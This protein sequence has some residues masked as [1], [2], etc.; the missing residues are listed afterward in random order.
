MSD[1]KRLVKNVTPWDL[2]YVIDM[3]IA[4]GISYA[5]I[6]RVLVSFVDRPDDL[7]GG[8]WAV[9]ATVFVF[10]DSRETS[11]AAGRDR[12]IA[13]GISFA[14]CLAYFLIVPFSPLGMGV[15]I[16][17][18]SIV[19]IL[20]G[21]RD[22]IITTGI[23]TAVVMVAA[24]LSPQQAW[25]QPLLRLIDTAVGIGVGVSCKWAASYAFYRLV[26]EPVR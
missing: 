7:L 24:A 5:I 10:R 23:T 14:P 20:I 11:L 25:H 22:D 21:R 8:M 9:V 26:G 4:C 13:T 1:N 6:T 2:A 15:V 16:G 17:V 19:M 3:A 12:L 18:G